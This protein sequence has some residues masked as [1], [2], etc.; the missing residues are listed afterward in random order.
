ML[1]SPSEKP[2][3]PAKTTTDE[4]APPSKTDVPF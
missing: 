4:E 2:Q 1:A 3:A